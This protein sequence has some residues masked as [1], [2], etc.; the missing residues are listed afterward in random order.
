MDIMKKKTQDKFSI[1]FH[2][3]IHIKCTWHLVA[4]QSSF[5]EQNTAVTNIRVIVTI[6]ITIYKYL[7]VQVSH[8]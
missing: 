7:V 1:A 6:F 8:T 2:H 3:H 5:K 4:P